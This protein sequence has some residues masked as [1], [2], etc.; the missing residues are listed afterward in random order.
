MNFLVC[1]G[2]YKNIAKRYLKELEWYMRKNITFDLCSILDNQLFYSYVWERFYKL[3]FVEKEKNIILDFFNVQLVKPEVLPKLCCL[4]LIAKRHNVEIEININPI[5]KVKD[6]LGGIGF[7]AQV[8]KYDL[9]ILNEGQIGDIDKITKAT[10]AFVCFNKKELLDKYQNIYQ[11]S[12]DLSLDEVIKYCVS[13]EIFGEEYLVAPG[14]PSEERI[15]KSAILSI[16]A[17][18][19]N[20]KENIYYLGLDFVELIHNALWHADSLCFF[21]LQAAT[22]YNKNNGQKFRRI[23]FSVADSGKGLYESL[24]KKKHRKNLNFIEDKLPNMSLLLT[25]EDRKNY[26][27]IFEMIYYRANDSDRGVYDIMENLFKKNKL[28]IN[29]INNNVHTYFGNYSLKQILSRNIQDGIYVKE[30][31]DIDYGFSFDISFCK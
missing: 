2:D 25:E 3:V 23:D 11:F 10:N 18:I 7:F 17:E 27:S 9:F 1:F 29:I 5:S 28:K 31:D 15:K 14:I 19:D 13:A 12:S 24:C 4:G 20:S 8:K 16:L 30:K 26:Y 22:Y 21:S 6:F